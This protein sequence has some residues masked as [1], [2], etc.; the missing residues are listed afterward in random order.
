MDEKG[1][2]GPVLKEGDVL[3]GKYTVECLIGAGGFGRT[4]RMRD[5]L[6]NIPVAVKELRKRQ[7][8]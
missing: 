5:N 8:V 4:Y 2:A 6:L 7:A 3:N 1:L